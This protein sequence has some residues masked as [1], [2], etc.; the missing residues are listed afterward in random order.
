M[1]YCTCTC[2]SVYTR[3]T[4]ITPAASFFATQLGM[5]TVASS[6]S[7]DEA[8]MVFSELQKARRAFVLQNELHIIYQ[9]RKGCVGG[10]AHAYCTL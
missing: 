6:L 1:L 8:L 7:P 2:G 9:V 5:A 4:S 3:C 10:M